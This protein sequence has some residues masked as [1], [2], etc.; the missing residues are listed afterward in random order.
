MHISRI[1]SINIFS[2]IRFEI[3]ILCEL[4][5]LQKML[6]YYVNSCRYYKKLIARFNVRN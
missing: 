2:K 6:I 5:F 4:R 3:C 1:E